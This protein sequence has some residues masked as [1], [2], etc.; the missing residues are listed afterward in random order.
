MDTTAS[1]LPSVYI[2]EDDCLA[3]DAAELYLG[4]SSS[5]RVAGTASLTELADKNLPYV[6]L[7]VLSQVFGKSLGQ[8]VE[9][10]R[11]S[12]PALFDS[13]TFS[14]PPRVLLLAWDVSAEDLVEVF[15]LDE[16]CGVIVKEELGR[17]L[18]GCVQ[19]ALQGKTI[20]SPKVAEVLLA[21]G[22]P[23]SLQ[24]PCLIDNKKILEKDPELFSIVKAFSLLGFSL[25]EIAAEK[26]MSA[27]QAASKLRS[28]YKHLQVKSRK[29]AFERMVSSMSQSDL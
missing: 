20:F 22:S 27:S 9:L 18:V 11:Q 1:S 26:D 14:T 4:K 16:V 7:I 28:A 13:Q 21:S 23:V 10:L 24:E 6:N 12:A 5:Q 2:L 15:S 25:E 19:A 29:E 3:R 17:N 8:S